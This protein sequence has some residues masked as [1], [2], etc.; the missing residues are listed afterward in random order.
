LVF[1]VITAAGAGLR[2]RGEISKLEIDI[3]GKPLVLYALEAFQSTPCVESLI[4]VVPPDRLDAWPVSR[5]LGAGIEKAVAVVAG[6]ATRQE[7]VYLALEEIPNDSGTVV[8]HDGARPLATPG[9][10]EAAC[11]A[12]RSEEAVITAV[13]LT[14]TV[15][16][17]EG[18]RVVN[19]ADRER[20]VA[21]QTPQA[22]SLRLLREA[23][24]RARQ[25]EFQGTD[26]ASLVE[27]LGKT[28]AVIDGSREN[29]KVTY[30]EDIVMVEA[31]LSERMGR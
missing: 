29:I 31:V 3:L 26:D 25:E 7:S 21:V 15:K 13:P 2:L 6:G 9:M 11:S 8:V 1:G 10:I 22:F 16:Q 23:H 5:L 17:V 4:L 19:T 27:R 24:R 14:D 30:P 18:G 28:V 20:L 12:A